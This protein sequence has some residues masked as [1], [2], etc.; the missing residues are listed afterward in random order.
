MTREGGVG[1]S[2][3]LCFHFYFHFFFWFVRYNTGVL[4]VFFF[5]LVCV[6]L[7]VLIGGGV[8]CVMLLQF[9]WMKTRWFFFLSFSPLSVFTRSVHVCLFRSS[10]YSAFSPFPTPL[11]QSIEKGKK[12]RLHQ[13]KR[14]RKGTSFLV[15]IVVK[16]SHDQSQRKTEV[17]MLF[18]LFGH[19][20]V[21]VE[22]QAWL[23]CCCCCC[24]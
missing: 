11:L 15:I 14:G 1:C 4:F 9:A 18:P 8:L 17:T 10:S 2:A 24:F 13:R 21:Y 23:I 6:C 7:A 19:M 12:I 22:V 20:C 5:Y 3:E 16:W